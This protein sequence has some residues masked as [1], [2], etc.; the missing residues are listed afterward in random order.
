MSEREENKGKNIMIKAT[1]KHISQH[2]NYAFIK[3]TDRAI[4][5][6]EFLADATIYW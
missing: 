5:L 4:W 2:T 3:S 6:V 1:D